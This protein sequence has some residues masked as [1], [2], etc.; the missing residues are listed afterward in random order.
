MALEEL[1]LTLNPGDADA[2]EYRITMID[3][4]SADQSKQAFSVAPPGLGPRDNILLGVSGMD[5][6]EPITFAVHNDGTDKADGTAPA[7]EFENDTVVT[8]AEQRNYLLDVIH[9]RDFTAEWELDHLTG[10]FYDAEPVFIENIDVPGIVQDSPRWLQ[11]TLRLRFGS[12]T[13]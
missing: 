5:R 13:G 6:S 11:A 12:S 7:G 4:T 3:E 8:L 9:S 2:R 1:K 10:D